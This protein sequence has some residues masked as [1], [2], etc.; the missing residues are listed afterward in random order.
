MYIHTPEISNKK[1][2]P[3]KPFVRD[4]NQWKPL[5]QSIRV[6]HKH[7][8]SAIVTILASWAT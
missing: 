3:E 4:V 5:K 8:E 1:P 7:T 2:S 6:F